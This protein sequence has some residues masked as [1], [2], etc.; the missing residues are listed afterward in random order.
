MGIKGDR[1]G[2]D[3]KGIGSFVSKAA[4]ATGLEIIFWRKDTQDARHAHF[5]LWFSAGWVVGTLGAVSTRTRR[6]KAAK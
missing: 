1:E 3:K 4:N 6:W 5:L 2:G